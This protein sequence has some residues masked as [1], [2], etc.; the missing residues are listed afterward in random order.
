LL[1]RQ[2]A[3]KELQIAGF[4]QNAALQFVRLFHSG[5]NLHIDRSAAVRK[6]FDNKGVPCLG[7]LCPH[8]VI[9]SVVSIIQ[10]A[11]TDLY[12]GLHWQF[13]HLGDFKLM[14]RVLSADWIG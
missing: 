12:N 13:F 8:S 5:L 4:E 1:V 7:H 10:I 2:Q 3:L 9:P 6:H 14:A 11:V